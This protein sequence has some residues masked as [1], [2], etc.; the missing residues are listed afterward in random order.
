MGVAVGGSRPPEAGGC[1]GGL[2]LQNPQRASGRE[3][4]EE[5]H[6]KIWG[7][8]VV[9]DR[10]MEMVPLVAR[11]VGARWVWMKGGV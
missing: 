8:G 4:Y 2:P 9:C 3:L 5:T 7:E 11:S 10:R 1:S 6:G